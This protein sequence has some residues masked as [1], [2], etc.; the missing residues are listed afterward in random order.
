MTFWWS[1]VDAARR[2][3]ESGEI[4]GASWEEVQPE[5]CA[6]AARVLMSELGERKYKTAWVSWGGDDRVGCFALTLDIDT[7]SQWLRD[8]LR[9]ETGSG[10]SAGW[11]EKR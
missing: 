4:A 3:V 5:I 8:R 10:V 1:V 11:R 2:P 6:R 7:D 9:A